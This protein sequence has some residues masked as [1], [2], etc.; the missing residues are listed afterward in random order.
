MELQTN[1]RPSKLSSLSRYS[2]RSR[3]V[4]VSAGDGTLLASN[5]I[6]DTYLPAMAEYTVPRY[7][8]VNLVRGAFQNIYYANKA[9]SGSPCSTR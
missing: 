3:D 2:H 4:L 8:I 5:R 1:R 7:G 9:G 6:L